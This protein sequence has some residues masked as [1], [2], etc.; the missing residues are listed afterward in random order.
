MLELFEV[1]RAHYERCV[2]AFERYM[3][4][5]DE[6]RQAIASVSDEV[7]PWNVSAFS[8]FFLSVAAISTCFLGPVPYLP[9]FF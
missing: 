2:A 8:C 4:N 3:P 9:I 1:Q 6:L 7:L 5:P